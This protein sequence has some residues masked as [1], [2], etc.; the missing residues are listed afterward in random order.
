MTY[1]LYIGPIHVDRK[2][3]RCPASFVILSI[4]FTREM[5]TLVIDGQTVGRSQTLHGA[6]DRASP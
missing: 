2:L 1:L 3:V 5:Y 4:E 6:L